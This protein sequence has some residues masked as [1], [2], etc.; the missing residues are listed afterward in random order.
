MAQPARLE[1]DTAAVSAPAGAAPLVP[2]VSRDRGDPHKYIIAF[3]VVLAALMQVIDSSIVNVALPDMMGNLGAEPRRDRVG[4]HRL[5]P[6]QRHRHPAHRMA[7]LILRSQALL[8]RLDH[9]L[10][11]S[12]VFCAARRIRSA[13]SS[14]GASCKGLAAAR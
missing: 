12:R 5:H 1:T 6:R 8:R 10:H 14:S 9:H 13:R 3:A 2:L 7:R 4:I 11:A